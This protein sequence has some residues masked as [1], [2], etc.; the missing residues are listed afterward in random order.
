M[1]KY[2]MLQVVVLLVCVFVLPA[3]AAEQEWK[4]YR[5]FDANFTIKIPASWNYLK[6]SDFPLPQFTMMAIS[7]K[8]CG[9]SINRQKIHTK[10]QSFYDLSTTELEQ[11]IA[12]MANNF[13]KFN[14]DCEYRSH[15]KQQTNN[16]PILI[17]YMLDKSNG[18]NILL[19]DINFI[20]NG[21][22]YEITYMMPE[23]Y[24]G[25]YNETFI[26]SMKSLE[27]Y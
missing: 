27:F 24:Y 18:Y 3:S 7:D 23:I 4:L 26:E 1:R 25:T 17:F 12:I 5:D 21:Y 19:A 6:Q 8:A 20:H 11:Y 13:R 16:I 10:I 9:I 2:V 14:P 15:K 22:N